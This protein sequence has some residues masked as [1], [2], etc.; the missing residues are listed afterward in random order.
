MRTV[1][2]PD[3]LGQSLPVPD[4][5][6]RV[7]V[8]VRVAQP[9]GQAV[10]IEVLQLRRELAHNPGFAFRRQPGQGQAAPDERRPVTHYPLPGRR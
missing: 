7:R 3:V 2:Q 1:G 10:A 5:P 6:A 8:G 4:L 9:A